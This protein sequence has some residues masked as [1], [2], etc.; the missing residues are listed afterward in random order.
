MLLLLNFLL[1]NLK[2]QLRPANSSES[3]PWF[4]QPVDPEE[5]LLLSK[6][7]LGAHEGVGLD[8]EVI[9]YTVFSGPKLICC[10]PFDFQEG[11]LI[12]NIHLF[13]PLEASNKKLSF[14]FLFRA[15]T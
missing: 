13:I 6:F 10:D 5:V 15:L 11:W 8:V 1:F 14:S 12:L 7:S 2:S 9:I 4:N 3:L